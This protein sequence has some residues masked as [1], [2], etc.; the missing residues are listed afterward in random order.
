MPDAKGIQDV[1][2]RPKDQKSVCIGGFLA[3]G[4]PGKVGVRA[5]AQHDVE[6]DRE[7]A[8]A[9]TEQLAVVNRRDEV[10]GRVEKGR[11][12]AEQLAVREP[13]GGLGGDP[14]D[15]E[16]VQ[17][18]AGH[19]VRAGGLV[20]VDMRGGT[21]RAAVLCV[22]RL[23]GKQAGRVGETDGTSLRNRRLEADFLHGCNL[24]TTVKRIAF[25]RPEPAP[26]VRVIIA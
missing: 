20:E 26:G 15:R 8:D 3:L 7:V 19:F 4:D 21:N 13:D 14:A 2:H 9:R 11:A 22:E 5:V 17:L 6:R 25:P 16:V 18:P 12:A 10:V 1:P 24:R 23:I